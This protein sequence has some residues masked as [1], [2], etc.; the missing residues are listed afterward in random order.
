MKATVL[1]LIALLFCLGLV[2]LPAV[3][4]SSPGGNAPE[5]MGKA[6]DTAAEEV[7]PEQVSETVTLPAPVCDSNFSLEE[8]LF[9]RVSM[10]SFSDEPLALQHAAQ[11]LW[12]AQG[13]GVDGVSGASRTA[14]SAGATHPMQIYF[15]AG[16][17]GELE[18]GVYRYN[19]KEHSLTTVADGD[20][21]GS[22]AAAALQ[23]SFVA[24]APA[25]IVLAADYERT[26]GRYGERGL[27]YVHMEVGHI[28]QNIS[29][30]CI[31]LGMGSVAVGAFNDARVQE[32]L[33]IDASPLMIIPIGHPPTAP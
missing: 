10:R 21:R 2:V 30:Q 27:R 1:L 3:G 11:L 4:C 14:P 29:L 33:E 25:C 18:P 8:S 23:Q 22:L 7:L 17:V 19:F 6:N 12:A 5:G 28:T 20:I 31:S 15:V 24:A 32:L 9:Q 26:T 16:D 13:V